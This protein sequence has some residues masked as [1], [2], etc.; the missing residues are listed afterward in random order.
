DTVISDANGPLVLAGI[1]G[2]LS[3]GVSDGTTKVLIEV[4]NWQAAQVRRTSTRLGLR[5]DS[6]QRYEKSLD[7][8]LCERTLLRTLELLQ[9]LCP[10]A[11][12][13]GSI[14]STVHEVGKAP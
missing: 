7:S 1:M 10:K 5:T 3:S 6:S 13:V 8:A 4:A 9:Q 14:E 11:A 12:P 2:G